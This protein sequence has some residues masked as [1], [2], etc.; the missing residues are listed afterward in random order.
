LNKK[1]LLLV[2]FT[3]LLFVVALPFIPENIVSHLNVEGNPTSFNS[4]YIVFF[5]F[6]CVDIVGSIFFNLIIEKN[7]FLSFAPLKQERLT[8]YFSFLMLLLLVAILI[9]LHLPTV[10][11]GILIGGHLLFFMYVFLGK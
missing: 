5:A 3:I 7:Q 8:T 1:S 11:I 4:K 2:S 9:A 10:A 6:S